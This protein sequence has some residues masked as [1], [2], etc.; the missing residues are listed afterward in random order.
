MQVTEESNGVV[1][2]FETD[3][4]TALLDV[5]ISHVSFMLGDQQHDTFRCGKAEVGNR[6]HGFHCSPENIVREAQRGG[7]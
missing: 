4:P 1:R 5:T 7:S 3:V 6:R 2:M